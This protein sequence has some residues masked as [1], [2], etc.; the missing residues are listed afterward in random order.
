M[1]RGWNVY[2]L[3]ARVDGVEGRSFIGGTSHGLVAHVTGERP[4]SCA[5]TGCKPVPRE[6]VFGC[7]RAEGGTIRDALS[8]L[9]PRLRRGGSVGATA[10]EGFADLLGKSGE[11]FLVLC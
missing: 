5:P 2:S 7:Q 1:R 6:I 11:V 4:W 8:S 9:P 10:F 3:G